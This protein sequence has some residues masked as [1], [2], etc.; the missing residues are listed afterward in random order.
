MSPL[1]GC[2]CFIFPPESGYNN[3]IPS[4]L[5]SSCQ[6]FRTL[7]DWGWILILDTGYWILDAKALP[8]LGLPSTR[9]E[10]AGAAQLKI[11]A[12]SAHYSLFGAERHR[13]V[14]MALF[15]IHCSLFIKF[16]P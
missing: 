14:G 7:V 5:M 10:Q 4:G 6:R 12:R 16:A 11:A 13:A 8:I 3:G 2:T 9:E 15:I 1:R